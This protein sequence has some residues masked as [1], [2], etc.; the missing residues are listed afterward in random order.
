MREH[1]TNLQSC[2]TKYEPPLD[3]YASA[4][5]FF[6]VFVFDL[7]VILGKKGPDVQDYSPGLVSRVDDMYSSCEKQKQR[8]LM[9]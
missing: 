7:R 8:S 5:T 1:D 9:I 6:Q 3:P 4:K 2:T